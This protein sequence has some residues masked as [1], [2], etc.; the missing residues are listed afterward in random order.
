MKIFVIGFGGCE[1]VLVWKLVQFF[2][3]IDVIV[4]F[5][6]VGIVC[7]DKCCNV[8]VK[9]IDIDGLLVLVQV[10]G[11]V[12]IV[13]GLEVLFVVGVVDCFCV[14]GLCIFGLIVV[15]VQLEGSKV[16]VKDFLVCYNIFIVFYVVYIDVDVVLVYI[17]E[18]GVLIVVKVDG[19]VV[20]KGVIVVMML[21]EVEDVVCDMF[22][23]NVFGDVGVCV[24]IEEFFGGEEVSFILMV[25]GVYVL[26]MVILQDYKCVGDGD[27]GFNMGGMGVYLLV[28]VVMLEVYVCVM[29]EVVNLIVQGMIVDG[30]L[31]IGFFYVGLMIDVSGVLKVIEFNVC[32]GD[33]EI[34][35]V[36]LC[37][38][39]D[40]VE[41]VEVVIDGC[42]DQV[43][44]QWDVCLLLGVVLVVKFYL[45]VLIIG[46]VIFGLGDVLVSVKVFYV[47]MVLD[48]YGQVVSVGGCVLCVV[49]LGDSVCDVQMKVYVGVV[50]VSWVNEFYC[51]DI[52]WCVIVCEG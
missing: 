38:Q 41:L 17:C 48:V 42:L 45:E 14:V 32:F 4:V 34:Q 30:I 35:L 37:L 6:N 2:C 20:G 36:M 12:L 21:V 28:L 19:L 31:F 29:C 44:V 7:E 26:L 13:V 5:G 22:F 9:V 16:Y 23:G 40:L 1:Y 18:K 24:V 25:D 46:D 39:L 33:L 10:E 50:K 49:V 47:G 43:E 51:N 3:V 11:V 8:V 15:V 27:I 52:G